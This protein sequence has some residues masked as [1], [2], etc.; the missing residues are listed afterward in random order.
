MNRSIQW[1]LVVSYVALTLLTAAVMGGLAYTFVR[2]YAE[3]QERSFLASNADAVALQARPFLSPAIRHPDLQQLVNAAS[4]LE[5][6][7]AS[8]RERV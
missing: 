1:R 7:R 3:Q 4:F 8:C 6:G 5:I 2:Q